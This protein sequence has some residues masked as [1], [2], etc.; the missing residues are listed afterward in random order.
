MD[1]RC[2]RALQQERSAP[3]T[4]TH[5]RALQRQNDMNGKDF[6][7]EVISRNRTVYYLRA[8]DESAAAQ[9]AI[10][11]WQRDEP[12][13]L[14]GPDQS[15]L[16]AV[17]PVELP[18]ELRHAQDDELI[19]RFLRERENLILRVGGNPATPSINDAISPH[20]AARG[21]GWYEPTPDGELQV[22]TN[23]AARALDRLYASKKLACF[24][25]ERV[26]SGERGEVCLYCTPDYLDRLSAA[27]NGGNAGSHPPRRPGRKTTL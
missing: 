12:S 10:S 2:A 25:R 17:N 14:Q 1:G 15:E 9:L 21:L 6:Q 20:Q 11:R 5:G 18:D 26:R 19:L 16:I 4:S 27:M 3:G 24:S 22:D 8:E 13:D 7:V 23:R